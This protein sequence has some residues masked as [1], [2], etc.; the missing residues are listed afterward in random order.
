MAIN[1][2]MT[3]TSP[4]TSNPTKSGRSLPVRSDDIS[5]WEGSSQK[6][7]RFV[8]QAGAWA[9]FYLEENVA[10]RMYEA[11]P[12]HAFSVVAE[13]NRPFGS[14]H[15]GPLSRSRAADHRRE[16]TRLFLDDLQYA[17]ARALW[18]AAVFLCRSIERGWESRRRLRNE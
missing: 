14:R 9:N 13:I 4:V 1:W 11:R 18:R 12:Y 6:Q 10:G 7:L 3:L 2:R 5:R 15:H 17:D 8:Y 16:G